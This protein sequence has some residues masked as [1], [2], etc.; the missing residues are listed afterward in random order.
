MQVHA[1]LGSWATRK[2]GQLGVVVG[3][4]REAVAGRRQRPSAVIPSDLNRQH[5][6]DIITAV[7]KERTN[8]M[9]K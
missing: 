6:A 3:G 1:L 9:N 7:D 4:E 2:R 5:A 8:Y